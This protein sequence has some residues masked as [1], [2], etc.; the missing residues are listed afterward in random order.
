MLEVGTRWSEHL[1]T[2]LRAETGSRVWHWGP[3]TSAT[4]T[5]RVNPR[6]AFLRC[7][8]GPWFNAELV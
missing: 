8:K 5:R 6:A 3:E 7:W 2:L 4:Q 1:G